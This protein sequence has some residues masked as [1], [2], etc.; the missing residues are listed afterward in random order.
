MCKMRQGNNARQSIQTKVKKLPKVRH[1]H[2]ALIFAFSKFLITIAN[3]MSL[4][5]RLG[6]MSPP[7]F[8]IFLIFPDFLSLRSYRSRELT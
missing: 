4:E 5:G 6:S 1:D 3:P 8:K 7:T 2:K